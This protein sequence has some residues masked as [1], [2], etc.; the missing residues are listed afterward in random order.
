[1]RIIKIPLVE[2]YPVS[3]P[4]FKK[5][6]LLYLLRFFSIVDLNKAVIYNGVINLGNW[7][8]NIQALS[9]V[10]ELEKGESDGKVNRY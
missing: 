6:G 3:R 4:P 9:I 1:M 7:R 5:P 10:N 8:K 2:E